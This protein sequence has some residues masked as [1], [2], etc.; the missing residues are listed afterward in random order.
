MEIFRPAQLNYHEMTRFHADDYIHF[1]QH[2][3]PDN[4]SEYSSETSRYNIDVDC[5]VFDGLFKFCQ[6]YSGG[7]LGGAYKLNRGTCDIAVNW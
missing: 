2:V 5:P 7:S 6:L 1:L 3:T 4:Q